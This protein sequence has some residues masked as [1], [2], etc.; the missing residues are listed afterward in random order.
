MRA[1]PKAVLTLNRN[2]LFFF[3]VAFHSML[4]AAPVGGWCCWTQA[5]QRREQLQSRGQIP[6]AHGW[7][8]DPGLAHTPVRRDPG[9]CC[10]TSKLCT[11]AC[12]VR[13]KYVT[14]IVA[15]VTPYFAF[16]SASL[17]WDVYISFTRAR[18]SQTSMW[19][20]A[21]RLL[22][23][24]LLLKGN[25]SVSLTL[26]WRRSRLGWC[27]LERLKHLA[28]GPPGAGENVCF[29]ST[30]QNKREKQVGAGL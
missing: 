11:A 22:Q 6:G 21:S 8:S 18:S 7:S 25:G 15:L 1:C 30:V 27:W 19:T 28:D 17:G 16:L 12:R 29:C 2:P 13:H 14:A 10:Q 3:F 9:L 20:W 4:L 5:E 26:S 23:L 24:Y